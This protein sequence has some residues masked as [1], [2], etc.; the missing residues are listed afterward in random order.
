MAESLKLSGSQLL[1]GEN[2]RIMVRNMC[3][4]VLDAHYLL[5]AWC[6][7]G[8]LDSLSLSFPICTMGTRI[9]GLTGLFLGKHFINLIC[10]LCDID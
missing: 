8:C 3:V 10:S 1:N 4:H 9:P 7:S 6:L 2:V 5:D